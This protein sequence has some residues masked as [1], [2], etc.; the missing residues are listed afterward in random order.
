MLSKRY[1][2]KGNECEVTFRVAPDSA[3]D[4]AL[5]TE[6]NNWTPIP[7]QK[8]KSGEFKARVKL[9]AGKR[10]QFRYLIDGRLWHN[11]EA[12][13]DY[14]PNEHGSQNSIVDTTG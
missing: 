4:V 7:M 9:P 8:L 1:F 3:T 2:K 11:D 12:A 5:L 10:I 14:V 6:A 13:D